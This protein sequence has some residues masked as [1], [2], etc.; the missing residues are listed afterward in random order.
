MVT[1]LRGLDTRARLIIGL[2]LFAVLIAA[3]TVLAVTHPPLAS[4]A[5]QAVRQLA[6]G[7]DYQSRYP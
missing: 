1:R 3:L 7:G 6:S 5:V 4:H 2:V